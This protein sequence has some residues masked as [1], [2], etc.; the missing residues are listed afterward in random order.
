MSYKYT[1]EDIIIFVKTYSTPLKFMAPVLFS[2][3]WYIS[4]GAIRQNKVAHNIFLSIFQNL[5]IYQES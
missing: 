4:L 1:L 3:I 5:L 2:S